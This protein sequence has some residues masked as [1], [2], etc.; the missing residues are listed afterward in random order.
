MH[1][2]V[3]LIKFSISLE[4][5]SMKWEHEY[6]TS[7]EETE[8]PFKNLAEQKIVSFFFMEI[9]QNLCSIWRKT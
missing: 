6:V 8:R 3:K 1:L 4:F 5:Y 9:V 2:R 7:V